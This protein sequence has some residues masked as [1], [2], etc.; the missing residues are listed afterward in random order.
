MRHLV[1]RPVLLPALAT[2]AIVAAT[3]PLSHALAAEVPTGAMRAVSAVHRAAASRNYPKLKKLMAPEFTWSFGGDGSADQAIERWKKEPGY[4]RNLARVTGL[5]CQYRQD[6]YVECPI[7]AGTNFR[8]GFKEVAGT[9]R[10]EYFV[11]GD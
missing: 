9:W 6:R 3:S 8:A 11:E 5:K 4:L 2:V 10:M 1:A 7:N